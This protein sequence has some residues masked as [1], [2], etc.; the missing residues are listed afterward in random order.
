[1][2]PKK[3][4][5]RKLRILQPHSWTHSF[6]HST[7]RLRARLRGGKTNERGALCKTVITLRYGLQK[8]ISVEWEKKIDIVNDTQFKEAN[9]MFHAM[10]VKLKQAGKGSVTHKVKD[11]ISKEDCLKIKSSSVLDVDTP[12]GVF[13]QVFCQCF[14]LTNLLSANQMQGF[15]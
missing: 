6:G 11:P 12:G 5:W 3:H 10:L 14:S 9:E 8:H 7:P 4:L 13:H 2:K 15:Q 1:M